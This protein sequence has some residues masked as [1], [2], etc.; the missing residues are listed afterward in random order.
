[1]FT[2]LKRK[3]YESDVI[4]INL[5]NYQYSLTRTKSENTN[6]GVL[7]VV[8]LEIQDFCDVMPCLLVKRISVP[9]FLLSKNSR[10]LFMKLH[11]QLYAEDEDAR[12]S[13]ISYYV[14]TNP[15]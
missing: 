2:E 15:A 4:R 3:A 8:L 1:M 7:K 14:L 11:G 10:Q 12:V 5:R 13:R 6:F 9:S